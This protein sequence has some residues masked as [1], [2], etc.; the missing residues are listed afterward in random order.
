MEGARREVWRRRRE[1][2]EGRGLRKQGY[3]T[4]ICRAVII[5]WLKGERDCHELCA[6]ISGYILSACSLAPTTEQTP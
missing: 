5:Q 1:E 3:V 4:V 2:D 6:G